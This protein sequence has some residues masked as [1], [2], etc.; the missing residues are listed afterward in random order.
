MLTLFKIIVFKI[1]LFFVFVLPVKGQI[2]SE[3]GQAFAR[4]SQSGK[5]ILLIFSGSDWCIPCIRME[6]KIFSDSSF[7][8]FA[9]KNLV[10]LKADF[11]QQKKVPLS[12]KTQY[13]ELAA[14]FN[15]EGTF[16]KIV[17]LDTNRKFVA[18]FLFNDQKPAELINQIKGALPAP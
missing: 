1:L 5:R 4:A 2:Y 11:P 14:Q 18:T 8:Q 9:D 16:P 12:L 10:M 3:P 17:L 15:A 7:R 13:E 6:K